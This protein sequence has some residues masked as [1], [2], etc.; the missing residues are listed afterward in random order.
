MKRVSL[1]GVL[2]LLG[3]ALV[4]ATSALAA[5]AAASAA[6]PVTYHGTAGHATRVAMSTHGLSHMPAVKSRL[7][8]AARGRVIHFRSPAGPYPASHS[9]RAQAS[10]IGT[11]GPVAAASTTSGQTSASVRHRFN[12]LSD[13]D[14]AELNGGAGFE[15]TPPDQGLCVGHLAGIKGNIVIEAINSA[16]LVTL[17][18]GTPV[19]AGS[20]A[21]VFSDPFAEGD[22]RCLYDPATKS[23][24]FTEIGFPPGGPATD[25]NNTTVDVTV[26]NARGFSA[27]YQFDTSLGGPTAGDCFGDQ[28][29]TGFSNSQLIVSTD[30]YCG[31]A[32]DNY[33]GA[34][35]LTV[36][37]SQL[38]AEAAAIS[39]EVFGP[40]SLAGIPGLGLDPAINTGTGTGYLVNSFPFDAAGNNNAVSSSL[41][42]WTVKGGTLTGRVIHSE[43]Y[44]FPV[45]AASTG[46]GSVTAG[47]TSEAFLDP[48]D[49]RTSGPVNVTRTASGDVQLWTALDSA[50][51]PTGD[52]TARDGAAWF[53][54]DTGKRKVAGQG[55]VAAAGSYLLYP[56]LQKPASGPAEMVF[57]VTSP[58]INPSSAFTTVGSGK[59]RIVAAGAGP[60]VSY[61]DAEF[62]TPRWGDYS[63]T[64]LDPGSSGVWLATEYIPPLAFQDQADNWGTSM[65][66]VSR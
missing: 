59:I 27:A 60:H 8:A 57:S 34:I 9:A 38:A 24:Y 7:A 28:P 53:R 52:P 31:P 39:D 65:F 16:V 2:G 54:I 35:V 49:S 36:P 62:G 20:L 32:E 46:D 33:Q 17:P 12:G 4:P 19:F 18:D 48:G 10:K 41:G 21:Q 22:P 15:V 13:A 61:S 40:V 1:I 14:Q 66:E 44:A 47:I 29:K 55:Y 42:L 26:L 64:A 43:P 6:G 58:S 63:F 45:P 23:F 37:K 11:S 30:E 50:V 25:F 3:F 5:P 56:A 51:A